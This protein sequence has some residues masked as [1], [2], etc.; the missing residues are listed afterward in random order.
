MKKELS[1]ALALMMAV[2][3]A[4][5][6]AD[7]FEAG[8][9]MTLD[10]GVLEQAEDLE[11]ELDLGLTDLEAGDIEALPGEGDGMEA[12]EFGGDEATEAEAP[13][14]EAPAEEQPA[15]EQPVGE[16]PA[17]EVP[18]EEAPA[19]EAPAGEAAA[20]EAAEEAPV[21][22]EA[23]EESAAEGLPV[24]NALVYNGEAQPLVS[25]EGAW[26]YSLDGETY[27]EAIP[28]A[29]DAGE[30]TVY[31]RAADDAGASSLT[32]VIDKAEAVFT[33]PVPATGEL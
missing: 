10:E 9:D 15:E 18:A 1:V 5:A 25:A 13:A 8:P 19:E 7:G 27:A 26:L 30:Y 4:S 22:E 14:G 6:M 28:T 11:L 2:L 21:E 17:E 16:A 32:A 23:G 29:V 12:V 20:E 31:Y 24:A 3:P 33:P